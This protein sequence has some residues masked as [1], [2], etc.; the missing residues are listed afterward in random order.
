[1]IIRS[2]LVAF[3]ILLCGQE[4]LQAQANDSGV[5]STCPD[6]DHAV[7]RNVVYLPASEAELRKW[8]V[9]K[10]APSASATPELIRVNIQVEG[11]R[12]FCAS[13]LNGPVEKQKA[14]VDAVMQWK[15]KRDRG[16]F[17]S[18]VMGIV[19]FRF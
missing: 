3:V 16:A 6:F 5:Y 17:K 7:M 10:P 2:A 8:A 14:A 9:V 15:F 12:V 1:M 13:A 11:E 4:L 18:D 19:S